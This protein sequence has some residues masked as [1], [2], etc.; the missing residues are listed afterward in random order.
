MKRV[1]VAGDIVAAQLLK[2]ILVENGLRAE[3]FNQNAQS[4]SGEIPFTHAYPEV[5]LMD[6]SQQS[7]AQ[8]IVTEFDRQ[9]VPVGIVYCAHCREENPSNFASCWQCGARLA[10]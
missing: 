7:Q 10:N 4:G 8:K 3:I 6:E 9:P 5:W 1:Y 2:D